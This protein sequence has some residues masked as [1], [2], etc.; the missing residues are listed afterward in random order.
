MSEGEALKLA[1]TAGFQNVCLTLI[2]VMDLSSPPPPC[3]LNLSSQ[4]AQAE[5]G[6]N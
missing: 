6:N 1:E 5:E 2:C 4:R 3:P